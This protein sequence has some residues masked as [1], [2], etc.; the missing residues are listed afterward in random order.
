MMQNEYN[1]YAFKI[2]TVETFKSKLDEDS[3]LQI[4]DIGILS[5]QEP[6]YPGKNSLPGENEKC[7]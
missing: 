2:E 1:T 3:I 7:V 5:Y 6:L 4:K